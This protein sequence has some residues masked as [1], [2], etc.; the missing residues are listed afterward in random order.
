[1]TIVNSIPDIPDADATAHFAQLGEITVVVL[2][3]M[4]RPGQYNE[5]PDGSAT[6]DS[7]MS[8]GFNTEGIPAS[9]GFC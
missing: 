6:P 9:N 7:A 1:M 3:C 8:P 5:L 2:R 4:P